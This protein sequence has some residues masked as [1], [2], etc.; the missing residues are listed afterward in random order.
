VSSGSATVT[1][2]VVS[3]PTSI[4][5][6]NQSSS[7][8]FGFRE[9][10]GSIPFTKTYVGRYS[11]PRSWIGD[12]IDLTETLDTNSHDA[13]LD[14]QWTVGTA[15]GDYEFKMEQFVS[16]VQNSVYGSFNDTSVNFGSNSSVTLTLENGT[17]SAANDAGFTFNLPSGLYVNNSITET[18]AGDTKSISGALNSTSVVVAGVDLNALSSCTITIPLTG[19]ISNS[20]YTLNSL[21]ISGLSGGLNNATGISRL[22]IVSATQ[23]APTFTNFTPNSSIAQSSAYS[24]TFLAEGSPVPT[25]SI[26]S[27]SL[28]TGMTLSESGELSGTPTTAGTYTFT[29][30]ASNGQSPNANK[31]ITMSV[32]DA[33][34]PG[35]PTINSITGGNQQIT[36]NFT[37]PSSSGSTSISNYEYSTNGGSTWTSLSPS[38]TS[39]PI[40]V[41]GLT[42]GASYSV[43]IKAVNNSGSG[44]A[45]NSVSV[46][47]GSTSSSGGGSITPTTTPTPIPTITPRPNNLIINPLSPTPP[48]T[49]VIP[50]TLIPGIINGP[51][52]LVVV[53]IENLINALRPRVV[54]IFTTP[55]PQPTT[56][57]ATPAPSFTNQQALD[58][59]TNTQDKKVVELPSL[60][61]YNNEFQP[62]KLVIVENTVAQVVSPGGGLLN[63]EAKDGQDSVPV[64]NRGRVQMVRSNNVETEG[65]GMAPNSEFAVYL[66]SDPILLGIGKTDARGK[67]FASFPVTNEL[68]IG[69]HT[70]QVNGLLPDGRATS[71]SLPVIVVD[72]IAT[73]KNQAMPQTIFVDVNPVD[74]ALRAVYWMLIVLAVMVFLIGA[75]YRERFFALVR[76]RKDDEESVQPAL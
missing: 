60:V 74:N 25:Y 29:V 15:A 14:M 39:S 62:S 68:P 50:P 69:D 67:F 38:S 1:T 47:L 46:T 16:V 6:V 27:G 12:G 18:C 76:R 48:P 10:G 5:S 32:V 13:G 30:T 73:A 75:S 45:S 3:T 28:P 17:S 59:L 23:T 9:V 7:I 36:I 61:L 42:N 72:T 49:P 35:S 65:T 11:T 41:T 58:L 63:V 4:S 44:S 26:S 40:I 71:V 70:L 2:G 55:T 8:Q 34:A 22:V 37:A 53:P 21:N 52:Q 54:D 56:A 64:D 19:P 51:R 66:F 20:G 43:L 33:N 31:S 57:G 24:Y